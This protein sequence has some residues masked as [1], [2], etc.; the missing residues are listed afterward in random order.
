M[1]FAM[2]FPAVAVFGDESGG[3]RDPGAVTSFAVT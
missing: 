3:F 1:L 2:L